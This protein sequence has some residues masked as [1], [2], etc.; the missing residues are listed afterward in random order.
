VSTERPVALGRIRPRDV[1]W[2]VAVGFDPRQIGV[3]YSWLEAPLQLYSAPARA[4]RALWPT[5][6]PAAIVDV[7]G[8]RAGYIGPNPLSGNLEYFL[9]P[10]ARGGVGSRVVAEYLGS[11]RTLDRSRCFFVAHHN[12]RSRATL[13]SAMARL[14]WVE[15]EQYRVTNHRHGIKV[16]VAAV[17]R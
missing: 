8:R 13:D 3:Q 4:V 6:P 15:G 16:R 12:T 7:E 14:G 11:Y 10:W 5:S 17:A 2:L 9:L 1:P